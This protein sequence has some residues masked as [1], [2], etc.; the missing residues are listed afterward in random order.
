MWPSFLFYFLFFLW[1]LWKQKLEDKL[2]V[3][4]DGVRARRFRR[5]FF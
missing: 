4:C 3:H 2:H 5:P 1:G